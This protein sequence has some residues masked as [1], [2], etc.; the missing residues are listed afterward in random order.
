[1]SMIAMMDR[2]VM[3]KASNEL[4]IGTVASAVGKQ[5]H[6][7]YSLDL[8]RQIVEETFAPGASVSVVARC[9]DV[10]AN[11]VFAWREKY[12]QG[13]LFDKKT[14]KIVLPSPELIQIGAVDHD[15]G[16]RPLPVSRGS[17]ISPQIQS[18]PQIPVLSSVASD[19]IE[20]EWHNGIKLRVGAGV[21]ESTL[22]RVL[23]S[24]KDSA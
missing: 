15:G 3:R 4:V 10:N 12:R 5:I 23:S 9:H 6:R 7:Q 19:L 8:K 1:M 2:L 24:L 22:R 18:C 20:I 16:I 14:T 21:D 11:L 13:A 17:S